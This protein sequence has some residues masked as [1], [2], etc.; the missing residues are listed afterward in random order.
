MSGGS[1]EYISYKLEEASNY[2]RDLEI[3][4]LLKENL[5]LYRL[6]KATTLILKKF[7]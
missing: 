2:A 1:Y 6:K 7:W 5:N 4:E 3:K